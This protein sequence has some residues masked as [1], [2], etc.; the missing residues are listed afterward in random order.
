M[1]SKP[2]SLGI[3][4]GRFQALHAGHE[5]MIRTAL[6]LCGQVGI[7]VGSSQ[8]SG[9]ANNPFSYD[10]REGLLRLLFGDRVDIFPLPDIG[11]GNNGA[12]GEYVLRNVAARYRR[13][14]DLLVSGKEAR[15][16]SWFDGMEDVR[17]S[18]LYIP[19][20]IDISAS[21]MRSF[22]LEDDRESWQRYTNPVLWERYDH[23]R[24]LVLESKDNEETA[25]L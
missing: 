5:Q 18:E 21:Q 11:V 25:S 14:P 13:V 8:E 22:L 12:W 15:R 19:K 16:V 3:L 20:A 2:F 1:S 23:L 24:R 17:I 9:T 4:V 7:F 6:A 10:T